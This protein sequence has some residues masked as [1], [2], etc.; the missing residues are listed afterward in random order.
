M[1][2]REGDG[3]TEPPVE[4][5]VPRSSIGERIRRRLPHAP[6]WLEG[7]VAAIGVLFLVLSLVSVAALAVLILN[8]GSDE[9]GLPVSSSFLQGAKGFG[10]G[11]F[12]VLAVVTFLVGWSFVGERI[13]RSFRRRRR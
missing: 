11:F 2:D 5:L 3:P 9:T 13:V 8:F 7:V 1:A 6:D 10:I 12:A 4:H